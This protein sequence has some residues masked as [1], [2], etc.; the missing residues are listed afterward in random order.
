MHIDIDDAKTVITRLHTI[1][2][3]FRLRQHRT[4]TGQPIHRGCNKFTQTRNGET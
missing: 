3:A 1:P 2:T 4:T